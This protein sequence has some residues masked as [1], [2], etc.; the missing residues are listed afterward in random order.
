MYF[1]HLKNQT[2]SS[3]MQSLP[4]PAVSSGPKEFNWLS[5][6]SLKTFR[7]RLT[8][9]T[10]YDVIFIR[11]LVSSFNNF[12]P[13]SKSEL[14]RQFLSFLIRCRVSE[15]KMILLCVITFCSVCNISS[16]I[17]IKKL[18]SFETLSVGWSSVSC[19]S[20]NF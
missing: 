15:K 10:E 13:H 19:G 4:V 14:N 17:T 8:I 7:L 20:K 11:S 5:T 2:F 9:I 12:K 18:K 1:L 6:V 16:Y 3:L